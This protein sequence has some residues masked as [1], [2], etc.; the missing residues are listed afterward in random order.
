[1]SNFG[2]VWEKA[3]RK[4]HN[5]FWL[6]RFR[7][8]FTRTVGYTVVLFLI[9][10]VI[11]KCVMKENIIDVLMLKMEQLIYG[12]MKEDF[13][14]AQ[15]SMLQ[16]STSNPIITLRSNFFLLPI[17][18]GGPL[19]QMR[20]LRESVLMAVRLNRTLILEWD[21]AGVNESCFKHI[22]IYP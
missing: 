13:C 11:A 19:Q 18:A 21:C 6:S 9:V 14:P 2:L 17:L 15:Q 1:M 20:G 16:Q 5:E 7:R 10:K 4:K 22:H 12:A 8:P 3:G